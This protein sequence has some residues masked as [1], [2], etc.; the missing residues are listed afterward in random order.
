[1][2][3]TYVFSPVVPKYEYITTHA[4]PSQL[5]F[6]DGKPLKANKDKV[7]LPASM[8]SEWYVPEKQTIYFDEADTTSLLTRLGFSL[9]RNPFVVPIAL[10]ERPETPRTMRS[11]MEQNKVNVG[12]G[13]GQS[14]ER[15]ELMGT[16]PG[17][18]GFHV[19]L[20]V[21]KRDKRLP[22]DKYI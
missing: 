12:P 16:T 9:T 6:L 8:L 1:M 21:L 20:L 4:K 17:M 13:G 11:H 7:L 14:S 2:R 15:T 18:D 10:D 22:T 19:R 3:Q 5:D